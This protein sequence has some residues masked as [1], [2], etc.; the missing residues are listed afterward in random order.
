MQIKCLLKANTFSHAFHYQFP[1]LR[2][3]LLILLYY[4]FLHKYATLKDISGLLLIYFLTEYFIGL[5]VDLNQQAS[6]SRDT[7]L[8][9]CSHL[10]F[11]S[12]LVLK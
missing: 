1:E 4:L 8:L 6:K 2:D 3:V 12:R 10:Y 9:N 11:Y 5:N 7:Y